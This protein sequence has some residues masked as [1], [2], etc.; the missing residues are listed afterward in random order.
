MSSLGD[1]CLYSAAHLGGAISRCWCFITS[2][3]IHWICE[4]GKSRLRLLRLLG[5]NITLIFSTQEKVF[6]Q[7]MYSRIRVHVFNEYYTTP[8]SF[9][10]SFGISLGDRLSGFLSV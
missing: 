5:D 9:W 3:L 6:R 2:V 10:I 1:I 8:V 7:N 4:W